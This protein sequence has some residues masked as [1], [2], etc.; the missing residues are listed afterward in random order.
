MYIFITE[1]IYMYTFFS[2]ALRDPFNAE[3][4]LLLKRRAITA[5]RTQ[6][7]FQFQWKK[8]KKKRHEKPISTSKGW[9]RTRCKALHSRLFRSKAPTLLVLR[10]M[11]EDLCVPSVFNRGN[12]KSSLPLWEGEG[13]TVT[14]HESPACPDGVRGLRKWR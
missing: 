2:V 13:C 12:M 11:C 1:K 10:F 3:R 6:E 4:I 9:C 8:K 5:T 14:V 7:C